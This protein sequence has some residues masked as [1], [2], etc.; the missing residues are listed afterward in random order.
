MKRP[1]RKLNQQLRARAR[2]L[3]A[4][5]KVLQETLQQALTAFN[6]AQMKCILEA[7]ARLTER[8]RVEIGEI[9]NE[10]A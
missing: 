5:N 7:G 9:K 1:D 3:M 6:D 10:E 8:Y 2:L 4:Q